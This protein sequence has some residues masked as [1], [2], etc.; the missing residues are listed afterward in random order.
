E[1]GKIFGW[2]GV[3]LAII[4]AVALSVVTFG[5]GS[6]ASALMVAGAIAAVVGATVGAATQITSSI[7]RALES[8]GREGQKVFMFTMMALQIACAVVWLGAGAATALGAGATTAESA[9]NVVRGAQIAGKTA[10]VAG[11]VSDVGAGAADIS[12]GEKQ[13][14]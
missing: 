14:E 7:P 12:A 4:A 10:E 11:G 1:I 8:V 6:A 9:S 2:I 3:G 13:A 5:A